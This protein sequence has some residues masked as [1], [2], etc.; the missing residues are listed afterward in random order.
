[1]CVYMYTYSY[2][3]TYIHTYI[4]TYMHIY[5]HTFSN[6]CFTSYVHTYIIHHTSYIIGCGYCHSTLT[7]LDGTVEGPTNGT[8]CPSWFFKDT[9]CPVIP[10]CESSLT[11]S[12]CALQSECAWCAS[13]NICTTIS[14]SF[15][16]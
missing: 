2:V 4:H 11:C 1:M 6:M 12:T 14:D 5:I 8:P 13:D 15:S 3:H 7:C 9:D 16:R 10:N